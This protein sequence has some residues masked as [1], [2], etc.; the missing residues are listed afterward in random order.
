VE[1]IFFL[2]TPLLAIFP[3]RIG[4]FEDHLE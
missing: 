3:G 1:A 2:G 4:L